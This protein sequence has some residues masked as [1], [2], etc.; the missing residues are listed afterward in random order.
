[1]P[2]G[3]PELARSTRSNK[4]R[5]W[6]FQ[7]APWPTQWSF[8]PVVA[9]DPATVGGQQRSL[10]Q[11]ARSTASCSAARSG[12]CS[13]LHRRPAKRAA[14]AARLARPHG[15]AA[16]AGRGRRVRRGRLAHRLRDV[17]DRLLASPA[18]GERWGGIGS[19]RRATRTATATRKTNG[20]PNA[21][22]YRDWV[23]D[24]LNAD[25]AF[26]PVHDRA[27]RR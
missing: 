23:V 20:R 17:V 26:R 25:Q 24:S 4:L 12:R 16:H 18:Y 8:A 11:D 1:M 2:L 6:I 7:G 9:V 21:W 13:R 14:A 19:I 27:A 22:R 5:R 3:Q 10:D 15:L